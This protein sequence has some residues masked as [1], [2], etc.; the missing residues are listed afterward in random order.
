M[1][2]RANLSDCNINLTANAAARSDKS[3]RWEILAVV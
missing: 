1:F 3:H 2:A